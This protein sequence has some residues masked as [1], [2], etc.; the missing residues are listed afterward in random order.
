MLPQNGEYIQASKVIGRSTDIGVN[1]VGTYRINHISNTQ[2]YGVMFP[3]REIQKYSANLLSENLYSKVDE[4]VHRYTFM[5]E[6]LDH[7]KYE[8]AVT[9]E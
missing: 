6:I 5:D 4:E 1:P 3:Y 8:T 9:K 2:V 7:R